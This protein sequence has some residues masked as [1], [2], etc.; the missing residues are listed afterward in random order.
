MPRQASGDRRSELEEALVEYVL[1]HGIGDL[2]LR[3]LADAV[4]TS[5]Y[6]LI[7]YFG[8][9]E[10]VVAAALRAI[11]RHLVQLFR[12]WASSSSP[13]DLLRRYWTWS[14]KEENRPYMKLF[15]EVYG[16]SLTRRERFP[17]FLDA[18]GLDRWV[19]V[20]K[21][22]VVE[23]TGLKPKDAESVATIIMSLVAGLQLDL[24]TSGDHE[25]TSLAL[26]AAAGAIDDL[27]EGLRQ[28]AG[29]A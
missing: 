28:A 9:K 5:T 2:S 17:G 29:G 4:G 7:Y 25:R 6:S 26:E 19:A 20:V 18:D 11:N 27:A 14:S 23:Q 16:L 8:N 13:G 22:L 12:E 15:Y 1:E 3:P 21:K 24:L 10:A